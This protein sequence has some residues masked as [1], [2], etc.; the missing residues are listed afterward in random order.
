MRKTSH[1]LPII[2]MMFLFIGGYAHARTTKGVWQRQ[3]RITSTEEMEKLKTGDKVIM[4]C[5]KCDSVSMAEITSGENAKNMSKEGAAYECPSCKNVAKVSYT[6][7]VSKR[8]RVVKFVDK[9]GE[10]CM[11]MSKVQD[12]ESSDE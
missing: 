6:G 5:R 7:P 3:Q 1:T 12:A 4:S 2:L 8:H 10:E 9:H 11:T